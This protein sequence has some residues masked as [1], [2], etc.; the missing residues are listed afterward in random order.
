M[1]AMMGP[2]EQVCLQPPV[3]TLK[4]FSHDLT[5]QPAAYAM[6]LMKDMMGKRTGSRTALMLPAMVYAH[7]VSLEIVNIRGEPN[8]C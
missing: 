2:C 6:Q 1:H 7:L 3:I 4:T 5:M 8:S